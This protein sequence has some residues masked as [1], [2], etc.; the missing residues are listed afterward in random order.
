M[1]T[2][3]HLSAEAALASFRAG[4]SHTIHGCDASG[5]YIGRCARHTNLSP[6]AQTASWAARFLLGHCLN[7]E[8]H[9]AVFDSCDF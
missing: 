3:R 6:T 7:R 9:S 2:P 1:G 5:Y 4:W 8:G